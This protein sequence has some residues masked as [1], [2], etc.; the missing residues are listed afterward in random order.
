MTLPTFINMLLIMKTILLSCGLLFSLL[1]YGQKSVNDGYFAMAEDTLAGIGRLV[2][3]SE[4]FETRLHYNQAL[5]N[6]LTELLTQE[7][8]MDYPFGKISNVSF[9]QSEDKRVRT[10]TWMLP[11]DDGFYKYFGFVQVRKQK[12]APYQLHILTDASEEIA[13]PLSKSLKKDNW[14][15]AIYYAII[16]SRHKKDVHYTLLGYDANSPSVQR[17]VIDYM[18]VDKNNEIAFGAPIFAGEKKVQHRVLFHY[19][20]DVS[21]SLRFEK[22]QNRIVFDHLVPQKPS[23]EGI[24]EFYGP[25]FSYDAYEWVKGK[26]VFQAAVD[27]RNEGLNEGNKTKKPQRKEFFKP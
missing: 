15:G 19:A 11:L 26:W 20:K 1:S 4:E 24:Y 23:L 6:I 13:K 18:T 25:D 16:T 8:S 7:Q 22:K 10:I 9:Q 21:M 2:L 14:Y 12:S 27:A 3:E 17:K 5:L